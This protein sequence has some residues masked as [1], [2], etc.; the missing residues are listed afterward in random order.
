MSEL[1]FL[2]LAPAYWE[3]QLATPFISAVPGIKRF[4]VLPDS[5]LC[6]VLS[7]L[8]EASGLWACHGVLQS[9]SLVDCFMVAPKYFPQIFPL[10][11][12][13]KFH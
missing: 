12:L 7:L 4:I 10:L 9:G 3:P 2:E 1:C 5:H 13:L 11:L 6:Q 8:S